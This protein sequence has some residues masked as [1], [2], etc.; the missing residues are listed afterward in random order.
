[1]D[2]KTFDVN[3]DMMGTF[4]SR[5]DCQILS[6]LTAELNE[7][8]SLDKYQHIFPVL[9]T[10]PQW[11]VSLI[12]RPLFHSSDPRVFETDLWTKIEIP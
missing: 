11:I 7:K 6:T 10:W 8:E 9:L 2:N 5:V 3:C 4:L 1:M 12:Q